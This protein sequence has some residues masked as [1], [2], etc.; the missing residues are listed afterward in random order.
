MFSKSK[1]LLTRL[2]VSVD[3]PSTVKVVDSLHNLLCHCCYGFWVKGTFWVLL[4]S[5]FN[6]F[7]E[8]SSIT[9]LEH[10]EYVAGRLFELDEL[11]YV[12]MFEHTIE[13]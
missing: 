2:E 6:I 12:W 8:I 11:D 7:P 3:H 4:I 5:L 10:D 1:V 9:I 13:L